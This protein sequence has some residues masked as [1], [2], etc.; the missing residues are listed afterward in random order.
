MKTPQNPLSPEEPGNAASTKAPGGSALETREAVN[1]MVSEGNSTTEHAKDENKNQCVDGGCDDHREC[2]PP[3]AQ[4]ETPVVHVPGRDLEGANR[5]ST[6]GQLA[7][8]SGKVKPM[9]LLW[10]LGVPIP[11]ILII[12]LVRGC[13]T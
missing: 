3:K 5:S 10:A 12:L 9:I 6:S 8:R 1:S 4:C 2:T 11:I 7:T 13:M